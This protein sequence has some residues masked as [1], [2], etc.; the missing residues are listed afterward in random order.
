MNSNGFASWMETQSEED[1]E[2]KLSVIM[3]GLLVIQ[4]NHIHGKV[5]YWSKTYDNKIIH[6]FSVD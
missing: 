2:C 4:V 1:E 5:A 3:V 6:V